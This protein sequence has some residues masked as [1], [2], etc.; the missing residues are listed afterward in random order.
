MRSHSDLAGFLNV[1]KPAGYTSHDVVALV[2][3]WSG[4]RQV[5]HGGTLDPQATGVLPLALG[6]CTRLLEFV[7]DPKVY[8]AEVV[9]GTAT[10]T[11]DAEGA[12]TAERD[13]SWVTANDVLAAL[14]S[15]VGEGVLQQ[16]PS[17]SAIKLGGHRA[18]EL[19]RQGA[20]VAPAPRPVSMYRIDLLAFAGGR[21]R[22]RVV[23]GRGTYVRSLAHDLGVLLGC[24]AHLAALVRTRNGPF[25]LEDSI[26]FGELEALLRDDPASVL[27]PAA[28][29]LPH[30]PSVRLMPERAVRLL[31]GLP[32]FLTPAEM[33][34]PR[35]L[36]VEGVTAPPPSGRA[37][38]CD[39][40]G[41]LLAVLRRDGGSA[42]WRPFKVF[43]PTLAEAA[44]RV[45]E[46]T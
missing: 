36:V 4:Q 40:Q 30:W 17:F 3:R 2:R 7:P 20:P 38:A 22:L 25:A 32:M 11:Y 12:V 37:L 1:N 18:Y 21:A 45:L 23:C 6:F 16:P 10:D 29:P 44:S 33:W 34:P 8:E 19:A 15:F 35:P 46:N 14:P 41:R 13:A 9:F 39:G 24:G 28:F 27:L 42:A 5:G 26:P 43:P 31:Q